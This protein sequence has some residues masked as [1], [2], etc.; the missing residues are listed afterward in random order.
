MWHSLHLWLIV[1]FSWPSGSIWSNILA[2]PIV[3]GLGLWWSTIKVKTHLNDHHQAKLI[4]AEEHHRE[5]MT[6]LSDV[7][8]TYNRKNPRI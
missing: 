1:F 8:D 5:L 2:N 7:N 3:I 4:Q 6:K